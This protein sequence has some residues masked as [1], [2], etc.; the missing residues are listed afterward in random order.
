MKFIQVRPVSDFGAGINL[1]PANST[2]EIASP[3]TSAARAASGGLRSHLGT[4]PRAKADAGTADAPVKFVYSE[5]IKL[6]GYAWI[7]FC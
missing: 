7:K 2:S 5:N 6:G 4:A 1:R 3:A